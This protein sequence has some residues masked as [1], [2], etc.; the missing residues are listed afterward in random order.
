MVSDKIL[1]KLMVKYAISGISAVA[2]YALIW[3]SVGFLLALGVFF[4][5][6]SINFERNADTIKAALKL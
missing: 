4:I 1:K 5:H 2:G 3:Y 6:M